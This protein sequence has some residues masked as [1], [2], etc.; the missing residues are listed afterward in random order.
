MAFKDNLQSFENIVHHDSNKLR[1]IQ[2][3]W[4]PHQV[5]THQELRHFIE[6]GI[7][8]EGDRDD[9]VTLTE[10]AKKVLNEIFKNPL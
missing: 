4:D 7:L 10:E 5:L 3:G 8:L 1:L 6:I 9:D 2:R